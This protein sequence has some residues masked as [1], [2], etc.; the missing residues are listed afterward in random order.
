MPLVHILLKASVN[1]RIVNKLV[2]GLRSLETMRIELSNHP[3][4]VSLSVVTFITTIANASIYIL[5]LFAR[6]KRR[7]LA[8]RDPLTRISESLR[9]IDRPLWIGMTLASGAIWMVSTLVLAGT[10]DL[11][12]LQLSM[13]IGWRWWAEYTAG[14]G[15]WVTLILY[16]TFRLW[17][18]F[19]LARKPWH[20]AVV[21]LLLI[22]PFLALS[23]VATILDVPMLAQDNQG[24]L[25]CEDAL[26]WKI[27]LHLLAF[28]YLPVTLYFWLKLRGATQSYAQLAP[29]FIFIY[30]AFVFMAVSM[31]VD[32]AAPVAIEGRQALA[33][34]AILVV[35]FYSI[36]LWSMLWAE[37]RKSRRQEAEYALEVGTTKERHDATKDNAL[38]ETP[39][40]SDPTDLQR[41]MMRSGDYIT[42]R[43]TYF[44]TDPAVQPS[45]NSMSIAGLFRVVK[46]ATD[47]DD[48]SPAA[49]SATVD[50]QHWIVGPTF[51][52]QQPARA[53]D[54][55]GMPNR[56]DSFVDA[57]DE[58]D[59]ARLQRDKGY[60]E[61]QRKLRDG[62]RSEVLEADLA[63]TTTTLEPPTGSSPGS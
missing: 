41:S 57:L 48:L 14:Y 42:R 31:V 15:L 12:P 43:A 47:E 50:G 13:C 20:A 8:S 61:A 53:S 36:T 33:A 30:L 40:G 59:K 28:A 25:V 6:R 52:M 39:F 54:N 34:I 26:G 24:G 4:D 2:P 38:I 21:F 11:I 55:E 5:Y 29:Y 17:Q 16:R 56:F 1:K 7:K 60:W 45:Q 63:E 19:V 46:E 44:T 9:R 27:I 22:S 18:A 32:I 49:I 37:H 62:Q 58:V 3:I 23:S 10:V 35:V 51:S